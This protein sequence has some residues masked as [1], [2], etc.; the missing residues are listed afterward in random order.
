LAARSCTRCPS[1]EQRDAGK[2]LQCLEALGERG[3]ADAQQPCR[4]ADAASIGSTAE[5]AQLGDLR[6]ANEGPGGWVG[7]ACSLQTVTMTAI[8]WT[9]GVGHCAR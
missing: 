6:A 3:L 8:S 4:A 1:F 5:G 9:G 2:R 7:G